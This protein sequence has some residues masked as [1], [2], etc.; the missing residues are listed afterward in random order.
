MT[1]VVTGLNE[2]AS[3]W[4]E[5]EDEHFRYLSA[6]SVGGCKN[7][8]RKNAYKEFRIYNELCLFSGESF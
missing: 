2:T 3:S 1:N 7:F 8:Y 5:G 4:L 6:Y